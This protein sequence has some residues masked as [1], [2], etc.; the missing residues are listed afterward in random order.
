MAGAGSGPTRSEPGAAGPA[1]CRG[2]RPRP[3]SRG[4]RAGR[5]PPNRDGRRLREGRGSPGARGGRAVAPQAV[6]T[7]AEALHVLAAK[8]VTVRPRRRGLVD[9]PG[10]GLGPGPASAVSGWWHDAQVAGIPVP[11]AVEALAAHRGLHRARSDRPGGEWHPRTSDRACLVVVVAALA[12]L[13]AR[14]SGRG[15]VGERT[16]PYRPVALPRVIVAGHPRRWK[17]DLQSWTGSSAGSPWWAC[18]GVARG[19]PAPAWRAGPGR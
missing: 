8:K 13:P 18:A 19:S 10:R 3:R 4:T 6:G 11:V 16:G 17:P 12:S 9:Q 7:P 15:P 2:G 1:G 14:P 5:A